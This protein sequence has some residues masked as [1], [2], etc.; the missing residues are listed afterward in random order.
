MIV[1]SRSIIFSD[2]ALLVAMRPALEG[3]GKDEG[4]IPS[5]IIAGLDT[6]GEVILTFMA[7]GG[8]IEF[9]SKELG[10]S[11]LNH[12]IDMGIPLPRGSYKELALRGD[13]IGLIVRLETDAEDAFSDE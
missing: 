7:D 5:E 4:F 13:H 10:A 3:R 11:I 6:E 2:E 8:D 1:E 12:C 9:G